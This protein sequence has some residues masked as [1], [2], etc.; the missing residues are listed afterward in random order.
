VIGCQQSFFS[1]IQ[2]AKIHMFGRHAPL[3]TL[4]RTISKHHFRCRRRNTRFL[5]IPRAKLHAGEKAKSCAPRA[6]AGRWREHARSH[7]KSSVTFHRI[8]ALISPH[9]SPPKILFPSFLP[10]PPPPTIRSSS[11][12]SLA[13]LVDLVDMS[14]IVG[15]A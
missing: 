8:G 9:G 12:P 4:P 2:W 14:Q 5:R 3:K 13:T 10:R 7:E 15:S 1:R 11:S 6:Q